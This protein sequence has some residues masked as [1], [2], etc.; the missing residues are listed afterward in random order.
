MDISNYVGIIKIAF[1]VLD[2][3][4]ALFL[5]IFVFKGL[6]KGFLRNLFTLLL[7]L[8]FIFFL[9]VGA[10]PLIRNA[11]NIE[12]PIN[13]DVYAE[14]VTVNTIMETYVADYVFEGDIEAYHNS[15]MDVVA[16]DLAVSLVSIVLFTVLIV[17]V[18][19]LFIPFVTLIC[20]IFLPFL[21]KKRDGKRIK[22]NL[23][24]KLLGLGCSLARFAIFMFIFIVP[25]Y[26]LVE[27]GKV[28]VTEA[29]AYD[30]DIAQLNADLDEGL[31][32]SVMLK[33][34]S[35]IGK[36]KDGV[37][38]VGAK[39]L[40]ARLLISTENGNINIIKELDKVG[41][42]LPRA[43][44]LI[45]TVMEVETYNEVADAIREDDIVVI[46]DYLA[47]SKIIQVVYPVA[48]NVLNEVAQK[49]EDLKEIGI[50][51]KE[52]AQ[53]DISK[54]LAALQ[55]FF[56]KVL[57]CAQNIDIDN[58]DIWQV[59][60]DKAVIDEALDAINIILNL[61]ITDKL[62][63][64]LAT[65]YLNEMLIE[66]E[67]GHLADL[68]NNDYIKNK[69]IPDI[70]SIYEI[71]SILDQ[72]GIIDLILDEGDFAE[73]EITEDIKNDL[74][75]IV[76]I[77]F[78][79]E[80][81]KSNEQKIVQTIFI[82][83]DFDQELIDEMLTETIDWDKEVATVGEIVVLA[84][85]LALSIDFDSEDYF[86][87]LSQDVIVDNVT[88]ILNK[89]LSMQLT[90]KYILPLV[91]SYADDM[92]EGM[93]FEELVGIIDVDYIEDH[94]INDLEAIVDAAKLIDQTNIIDYFLEENVEYEFNTEVKANLQ[95]ALK[96]IVELEL[97]NS[98]EDKL[99]AIILSYLP[100]DLGLDIDGILAE[101][102]D[103]TNE[104]GILTDVVVDVIEFIITCDFD[105][106]NLDALLEKEEIKTFIPNLID[107]L[108]SLAICE[109]YLAPI[110]VGYVQDM[111]EGT[112]IDQ[113]T[114]YITVDYLKTGF[115]EDISDLIGLLDLIEEL[116]LEDMESEFNLDLTDEHIKNQFR[117]FIST[118]LNLHVLDGHESELV[119]QLCDLG[120]L[121]S[122][123]TYDEEMFDNVDWDVETE[124]FINVI[125]AVVSLTDLEGFDENY[126]EK[127]N[128]NEIADQF[129]TL[130]DALIACSFTKDIAFDLVDGL[131][132]S[133]GY[134]V[135]LTDEDKDAIVAN[136]GKAE[137]KV[138][139]E[140]MNIV[141]DLMPEDEEGNVDYTT[142]KG[143]D[144]TDL[145]L[146]ASEGIIASKIMGTVLN[147]LLSSLEITPKDEFGNLLYDF[148]NPNTLATQ[149]TS[150]GNC[151]DLVNNL[152]SFDPDNID[153][154]SSIVDSLKALDSTGEEGN[155]V[156]DIL[157][158]LLPIESEDLPEDINWSEEADLIDDILNLYDQ[159]EDKDNFE[160][161][162]EELQERLEES[163]I[164][165][166]ILDFLDI[167]GN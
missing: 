34:T 72:D 39:T 41:G 125:M 40:G 29:A 63:L 161:E 106:D 75:H 134:D 145:M 90:E 153:S 44:E 97:I 26:G 33:L 154:V 146:K 94:F 124:N 122:F 126:L 69:L 138:L 70:K 6:R 155:I 151:I 103:W 91:V 56:I 35:N 112:G 5:V 129:G 141:L 74:E 156:E 119:K 107:K 16:E 28:I 148:T 53:I 22:Y 81:I 31:E 152:Q 93:G 164:A 17:F 57:H 71:Y 20:K 159:S 117:T 78:N 88:I 139:T 140:I 30:E 11:L 114:S 65:D 157:V 136:T 143:E 64:A 116:G 160:I 4:C 167:F 158:E 100:E 166:A 24:S 87:M 8:V 2:I 131:T 32:N 7:L 15:E 110:L 95:N 76:E 25:I 37:F 21:R 50:N 86:A 83:T 115:S 163:G 19:I 132:S 43:I 60:A 79:L 62:V 55:P 82:F 46:T 51:F 45:D 99:V 27:T 104:L 12:L 58:F 92:L 128:F 130:F 3:I 18:Y 123:I 48:M 105:S 144:I 121:D 142:L 23:T 162:D 137:F 49:D 47:E 101:D 102:I 89:A 80:L 61:E 77:I 150:I 113:F 38:G 59:L 118:I 10:K 84:I 108:F 133:I 36:A 149:A 85:E 109:E 98:N 73:F 135:S 68:I 42:Y 111:L 1:L 14:E 165:G 13:M 66:N 120:G 147:E 52:L 127:D 9:T 54:D 67:F 96:T